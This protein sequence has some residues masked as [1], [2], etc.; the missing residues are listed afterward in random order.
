MAFLFYPH[1]R[2][3]FEDL[4]ILFYKTKKHISQTDSI[5][6]QGY[7]RNAMADHKPLICE[8]ARDLARITLIETMTFFP[9]E[10]HKV[11][12]MS[13]MKMMVKSK[14]R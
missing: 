7:V 10:V 8:D 6:D 5:I 11:R 1:P 2:F 9:A 14:N 4:T 13:D 3:F 12:C